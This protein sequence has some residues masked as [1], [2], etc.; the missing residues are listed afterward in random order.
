MEIGHPFQED[1]L[2]DE[3]FADVAKEERGE[4]TP[5]GFAS[6]ACVLKIRHLPE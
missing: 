3:A 1:D 4:S 2:E 6:K 5:S